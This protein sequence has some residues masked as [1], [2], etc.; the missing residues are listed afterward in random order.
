MPLIRMQIC[1]AIEI[2]FD[3]S[4]DWQMLSLFRLLMVSLYTDAN[5]Y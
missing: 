5:I 1:G 4:I 2:G 3:W